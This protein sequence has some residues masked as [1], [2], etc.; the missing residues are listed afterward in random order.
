MAHNEGRKRDEIRLMALDAAEAI[1]ATEGHAGLSARRIASAAGCTP[2]MLYLVF[3]NLGD[4]I[5]QINGRTL[6][7]LYRHLRA[8]YPENPQDDP[9]RTLKALAS[10]YAAY[11]KAEAPRWNMLSELTGKKGDIV[12]ERCQRKLARIFGLAEAALRALTGDE[13]KITRA[14]T[15]SGPAYTVSVPCA[16]ASI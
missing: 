6:D 4:L 13:R 14:P 10:A 9:E 1:V 16:S 3:R 12:P 11:A 15:S 8:N 7:E 2:G 5:L